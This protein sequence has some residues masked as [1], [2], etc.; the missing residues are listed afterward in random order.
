MR[1]VEKLII[2]HKMKVL[3]I[4]GSG[5]CGST[6]L[7]ILL[8]SH[9][10]VCGVG[11]IE[12][13]VR[14]YKNKEKCACG[15]IASRCYFWSRVTEGLKINNDWKVGRKKLDI[16][17]DNQEFYFASD[18]SEI[19]KD[20]YI[21]KQ[22]ELYEKIQDHTGCELIVDSSKYPQRV[23]LLS[24]SNKINPIILHLVRDGKG[25]T[26]SYLKKYENSLRY[27]WKW[28]AINFKTELL[29]NRIKC[30][31][32]FLK[33]SDLSKKPKRSIE[34]ILSGVGLEYEEQMLNFNNYNNIEQHQ[35][36]GNRLK[37]NSINGIKEDLEWKDRLSWSHLFVFN[38]IGGL[39]NCYY[40]NKEI[41]E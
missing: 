4:L 39:L 16:L 18:G 2:K 1:F 20:K 27:I 24:G 30:N 33:Y 31:C 32:V 23:S 26:Y 7:D 17:L 36:G 38:I 9:S 40:S 28:F 41:Y 6:I 37:F 21:K 29:K 11:E 8:G 25:V 10:K 35:I 34:R 5:H 13:Y 12:T 14:R 15:E 22:E 19:N 3:F